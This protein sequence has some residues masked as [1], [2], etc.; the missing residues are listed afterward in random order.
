MKMQEYTDGEDDYVFLY[1]LPIISYLSLVTMNAFLLDL[2]H[3]FARN[4][5]QQVIVFFMLISTSSIVL[6]KGIAMEVNFAIANIFVNFKR[7]IK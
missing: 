7:N 1:F 6:L 4:N 5:W 2:A 3:T